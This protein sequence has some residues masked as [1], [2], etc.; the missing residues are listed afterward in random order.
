MNGIGG[1]Q[2][3]SQ[4]QISGDNNK[5][6]NTSNINASHGRFKISLP[7]GIKNFFSA[8]MPSGLKNTSIQSRDVKSAPSMPQQ[9]AGKLNNSKG[10]QDTVTIANTM[11]ELANNPEAVETFNKLAELRADLEHCK[12]T[13]ENMSGM[14]NPRAMANLNKT[15]ANTRQDI[16]DTVQ[17]FNEMVGDDLK[18]DGEKIEPPAWTPNGSSVDKS[19]FKN[20]AKGLN[21]DTGRR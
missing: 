6:T 19:N 15:I 3:I 16:Q 13:A 11:E 2:P 18:I 14:N 7:S 9:S 1:Q 8:L 12:G 17:Q 10:S 20:I 21:I 5:A 4:P